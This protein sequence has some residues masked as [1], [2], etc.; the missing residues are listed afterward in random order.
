[1]KIKL[2]NK[3]FGFKEFLAVLVVILIVV[4]FIYR[5]FFNSNSKLPFKQ[6]RSLAKD[7]GV[8]ATSVRDE[9]PALTNRIYLYD[10]VE[11]GFYDKIESPFKKGEYCDEFESRMDTRAENARS[12]TFKCGD[13]MIYNEK[14][15]T[16]PEDYEI[17]KVSAWQESKITDGDHS[18]E[19][20]NYSANGKLVLDKYYVEK[21]FIVNYNNKTGSNI[22]SIGQIDT[23]KFKLETK[24]FYRTMELVK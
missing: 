13:Y 17:Y 9:H 11:K 2:D 6:F 10:V 24:V 18:Q 22:T 16:S 20:Y 7:F 1:M 5:S 15:E 3:G 19:L 4:L 8:H 14:F 21:E 23:S 12:I